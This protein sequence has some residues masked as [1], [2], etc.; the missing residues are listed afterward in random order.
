MSFSLSKKRC[1]FTRGGMV[2]QV[3]RFAIPILITSVLQMT[4][5]T[6]DTI[7]VGRWGGNSPAE[8]EAA[9]AA[10]GS[11]ASLISL[12]TTFFMGLSVGASVTVAYDVGAKDLEGVKKTVHTSAAFAAIGALPFLFS[13]LSSSIPLFYGWAQ[14]PRSWTRLFPI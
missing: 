10:V 3:F 6:A 4:F 11:C 2:L 8:C 14:T 12:I 1:D 9:L 5:N 7:M 13:D